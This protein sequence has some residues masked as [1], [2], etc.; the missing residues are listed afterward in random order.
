M[1]KLFEATTINTMTLANRFVRSATW[2]AMANE[3]GSVSARAHISQAIISHMNCI[4][5]I[6]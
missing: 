2:M 6:V 1:L 4:V 3:D 5:Q